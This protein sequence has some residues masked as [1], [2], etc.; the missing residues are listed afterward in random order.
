NR[1]WGASARCSTRRLQPPMRATGSTPQAASPRARRLRNSR[2]SSRPTSRFGP[3]WSRRP[4]SR[5]TERS[6]ATAAGVAGNP[7]CLP[8]N[9]Q[10]RLVGPSRQVPPTLDYVVY[11]GILTPV[12]LTMSV[13]AAILQRFRS[14]SFSIGQMTFGSFLT[15]LAVISATSMASVIAI[16]HIDAT[17]AELQRLQNVGDLSEEIDRRMNELRLAARDFVTDP[18]AR[19]G[20]VSEAASELGALLK[21]TRLELAPEQQ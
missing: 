4:A 8:E 7:P 21:K 17:F 15:L 5:P 20:R 19:S 6:P 12:I 13:F 14:L 10:N 16:R 18:D 1:S 9:W 3:R 2:T 11:N